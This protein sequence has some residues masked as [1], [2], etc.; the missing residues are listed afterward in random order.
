MRANMTA[1]ARDQG[2]GGCDGNNAGGG[3]H[4]GGWVDR[5]TAS[6][7]Y[8]SPWE[9]TALGSSGGAANG[10]WSATGGNGGGAIRLIVSG[11][12]TLDG[13]ITANGLAGAGG[14]GNRSGGGAG[15][16]IWV[17]ADT[18]AGSGCFQA[19]GAAGDSYN[20]SGVRAAAGAAGLRCIIKMRVVL[21]GLPVPR[22][23]VDRGRG[24]ARRGAGTVAFIDQ[25]IPGGNLNVY[26][27]FTLGMPTAASSAR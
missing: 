7:T 21:R 25:S 14:W 18:L 24:A 12:L 16:S 10:S 23:R 26:Q 17:T 11:S 9:P 20:A 2:A 5:H 15:G 1:A 3:G 4:G 6:A 22:P 19:D 13:T 27:T 8:D